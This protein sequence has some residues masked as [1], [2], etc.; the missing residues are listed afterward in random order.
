MNVNQAVPL[1]LIVNELV[2]NAYEFAFVG[3][4]KGT[5]IVDLKADNDAVSLYV[6]DDGIGLPEGFELENSPTLGTTLVLSYSE[7]INSKIDISTGKEGTE[8]RLTFN[9][10]KNQK[11]STANVLV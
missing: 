1:A 4:E 10:L 7:Q 9:Y 11:G 3:M 5:I 6:K 2:S 8:Y